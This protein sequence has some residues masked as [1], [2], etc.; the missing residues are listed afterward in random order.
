MAIMIRCNRCG[1]VNEVPDDAAG[2]TVQCAGC[3]A[4]VFVPGEEPEE[5]ELADS[6]PTGA[7]SP[8]PESTG[9]VECP[10]CGNDLPENGTVC[11]TCG[12]NMKTGQ[13]IVTRV[14][15]D[16]DDK[17]GV[18]A[19]ARGLLAYG[20]DLFER[21]KWYLAGGAVL[22][23]V[24]TV[25]VMWTIGQRQELGRVLREDLRK[26]EGLGAAVAEIQDGAYHK[27][28]QRRRT[29]PTLAEP[30]AKRLL[31]EAV[32]LHKKRQV[33]EA[34]ARLRRLTSMYPTTTSVVQANRLLK[35]WRGDLASGGPATQP[36]TTQAAS[37]QP[38][39]TTQA[40]RPAP[41][42]RRREPPV[43][44]RSAAAEGKLKKAR[45]LLRDGDVP[46]ARKHLRDLV[47]YFRKTQ[48]GAKAAEILREL[49]KAAPATQPGPDA[50][51]Q[52]DR[53][54]AP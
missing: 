29:D 13:F 15:S 26:G 51:T 38:S 11:M 48:S 6:E 44:H 22:A 54:S 28:R 21:F 24:G 7:S 17:A 34:V 9:P 1:H 39:A 8:G 20:Q 27:M 35:Q 43:L 16:D 12:Y 52:P 53:P 37:S 31:L 19:V 10:K 14:D 18:G 41:V 42:A 40:A 2:T 46:G 30:E 3:E 49:S 32:S 25:V 5:L 36:A 45:R 4:T 50:A 23:V 33:L 47:A